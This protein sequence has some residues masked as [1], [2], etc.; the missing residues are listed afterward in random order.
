MTPFKPISGLLL[1]S[2][3]SITPIVAMADQKAV[4]LLN[5]MNN[6]LHK[7]SYKGTLADVRGD[8]LSTI[9]I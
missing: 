2:L 9:R 3:L 7:L 4:T 1:I 6:A 8:S 5:R